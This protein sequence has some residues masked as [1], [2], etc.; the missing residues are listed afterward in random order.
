[1]LC[2]HGDKDTVLSVEN[3][4]RLFAKGKE[5]GADIQYIEVKDGNHGFSSQG[6]P[7]IDEIVAKASDFVIEKLTK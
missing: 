2:F 3:A 7:T 4:R 1:V 5:V 6:T